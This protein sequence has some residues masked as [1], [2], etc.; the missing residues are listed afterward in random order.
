MKNY[1]KIVKLLKKQKIKNISPNFIADFA[2][3]RGIHLTSQE[4]IN[5]NNAIIE[6]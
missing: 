6:G 1:L 2:Y 3:N 5:I 4:V